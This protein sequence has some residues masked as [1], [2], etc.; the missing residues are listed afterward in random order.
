MFSCW[1]IRPKTQVRSYSDFRSEGMLW[2]KEVE[3][4]DSLDELKSC[5]STVGNNFPNIG[6]LEA[7]IASTPNKIIQNYHFKKKVSHEEQKAQKR[8]SVFSRKTH[9]LH[10]VRRRCMTQKWWEVLLDTAE[11]AAVLRN[12]QFGHLA[13]ENSSQKRFES[14]VAP[15]SAIW[16]L[17]ERSSASCVSR[18]Q[19]HKLCHSRSWHWNTVVTRR[20]RDTTKE[21]LRGQGSGLASH[22]QTLSTS[23]G[24]S[25]VTVERTIR[26][27]EPTKCSETSKEQ[28]EKQRVP[29]DPVPNAPRRGGRKNHQT[30]TPA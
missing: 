15:S 27:L 19:S 26:R 14:R 8:E 3:M 29:R 30:L 25:S 12:Q 13:N 1:K 20:D 10:D 22:R 16:P 7:K 2:I 24:Q 18:N 4:D 17:I 6:M 9:R 5:R 28:L 23:L 21:A 11:R